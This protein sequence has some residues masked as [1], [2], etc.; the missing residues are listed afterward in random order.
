MLGVRRGL[1]DDV[2]EIDMLEDRLAIDIGLVEGVASR[3][4]WKD[5]SDR[6]VVFRVV[7]AKCWLC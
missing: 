5:I 4:D 1:D 3:L 6:S 2:E 7:V